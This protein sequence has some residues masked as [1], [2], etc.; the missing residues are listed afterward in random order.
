MLG[1]LIYLV[2]LVSPLNYLITVSA[3]CNH[4]TARQSGEFNIS[5]LL[6]LCYASTGEPLITTIILSSNEHEN[7][8]QIIKLV[9]RSA[10]ESLF[11]QVA[12]T[13]VYG[14]ATLASLNNRLLCTFLTRAAQDDDNGDEPTLFLFKSPV[15]R[16]QA[17]IIYSDDD[18]TP[19]MLQEAHLDANQSTV[20]LVHGW[21]GGIHNEIWLSEAKNVGLRATDNML[22]DAP[23]GVSPG[24]RDYMPNMII[25]DWSQLAHGS[26]YTATRNSHK[27]ARRLGRLIG[28]LTLVGQLR[29]ELMHCLGH[30]IGAHICGQA[31][32]HAFPAQPQ[33]AAGSSVQHQHQQQQHLAHLRRFGRITGLDPGGFCYELGVHNETT[34][35]GLRPSDA[36]LVDAYYSNRSP[37]GNKYQVAHYNVRLDNGFFQGA[38]SVWRNATIATDYFRAALRFV[39]GN[40]AHN[41]ILTC[42]HYFAT[43]FAHQLPAGQ[44]SYVAYACHSYADFVRGRCGQCDSSDQCYTMDFEYQRERASS[45]HALA[46]IAAHSS[47]VVAGQWRPDS[48]PGGVPYAHRR[49]YYMRVARAPPYCSKL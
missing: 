32:R 10:V 22:D 29:P 20:I 7:R 36:L 4:T 48:P 37:F 1:S 40:V 19:A 27:V 39:L 9:Q 23:A 3:L 17:F 26:L 5:P 25:V 41:D 47:L 8:Q 14:G 46:H 33:P 42:D 31:A 38:C 28:Q 11:G 30:S 43:R 2:L 12:K 34:Y 16:D 6:P 24:G 15:K 35:L 21:L 18:V 45:A 44:C 13:V 49:V